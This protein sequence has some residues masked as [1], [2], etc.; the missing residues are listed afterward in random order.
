M[1]AI[2]EALAAVRH[3]P[4]AFVN[5]DEAATFLSGMASGGKRDGAAFGAEV[6]NFL[7]QA[8]S[9]GGR[10]TY[11]K[12]T[13]TGSKLPPSLPPIHRASVSAL[14]AT[15]PSELGRNISEAQIRD[16]LLPR[17][18]IAYRR[19]WADFDK[20]NREA[21]RA[22]HSLQDSASAL[23]WRMREIWGDTGEGLSMADFEALPEPPA[24]EPSA[25]GTRHEIF[26]DPV[27]FEFSPEAGALFED[28]E[29]EARDRCRSAAEGGPPEGGLWGKAAEQAKR[30][31]LVLAGVRTSAG[32]EGAAV[33]SGEEAEWAIRA[34]RFFVASGVECLKVNMAASITEER[35]RALLAQLKAVFPKVLLRSDL[36]RSNRWMTAESWERVYWPTLRESGEV[37]AVEVHGRG[38]SGQGYRF[39]G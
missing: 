28:F 34:V 2:C 31:A 3:H 16:G 35:Q 20:R 39:K 10:T 7:K 21:F 36:L 17:C 26:A 25:P 22:S 14:M 12:R 9:D 1:N 27:R 19:V 37:V 15:Q 23:Y 29:R 18:L 32:R 33:I 8:W 30:I 13:R 38:R 11:P 24:N 4:V 5:V 6:G